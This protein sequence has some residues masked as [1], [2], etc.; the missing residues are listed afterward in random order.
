MFSK[1]NPPGL[2]FLLRNK[3]IHQARIFILLLRNP[4]GMHF[5]FPLKEI[6]QARGAWARREAARECLG[7]SSQS[8]HGRSSSKMVLLFFAR[9]VK[10]KPVPEF[11][12]SLTPKYHN[13]HS[14]SVQH[15]QFSS[16]QHLSYHLSMSVP[17]SFLTFLLSGG[18]F[19]IDR[20][21][22]EK[23]GTYDSGLTF[24]LSHFFVTIFTFF[25]L[26]RF[27]IWGAENLE[28]SF[29][30]WMCGGTLEIVP[31][32]HV[33]HIFRWGQLFSLIFRHS[34]CCLSFL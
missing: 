34:D 7:T 16:T 21:F 23:L 1:R 3:E 13:S 10:D 22:F 31:C 20:A 14:K 28:L 24:F 2:V 5:H 4:P 25:Y 29:K 26:F 12:L 27:D 17:M 9:C 32:S 11:S 6:H 30:T 19:A 18:L 8:H 33:G 15:D